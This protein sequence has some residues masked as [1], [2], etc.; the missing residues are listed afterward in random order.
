MAYKRD[1]F[2]LSLSLV[3]QSDIGICELMYVEENGKGVTLQYT[4][5]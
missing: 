5:P 1:G 2:S 4:S 3:N